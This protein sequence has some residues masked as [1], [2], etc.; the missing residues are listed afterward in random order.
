MDAC[1]MSN[2]EVAYQ[3]RNYAHYLV[4][5]EETEPETGWPYS[6][7][8]RRFEESP[9]LATERLAAHMVAAYV[10][11]CIHSGMPGPATQ[12]ALHLA[13]IDTLTLPL[14]KLADALID[15]MPR[16]ARDIDSA[17]SHST[18]FQHGMLWDIDDFCRKLVKKTSCR[19]VREAACQVRLALRPALGRFVIACRLGGTNLKRC[20][21]VSVYLQP[22]PIPISIHYSKL[23]FARE[24][25]WLPMLK[26]FHKI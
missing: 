7:M 13:E 24:H 15:D 2:L 8:L 6:E 20:G 16:A 22:L 18:H 17:Q 9:D 4:A 3:V 19:A 23:D 25:R 12:S 10:Q 14:D 1:L 26:A 21:G 5:S 11:S